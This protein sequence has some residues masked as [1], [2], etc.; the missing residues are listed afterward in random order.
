MSFGKIDRRLSSRASLPQTAQA[1]SIMLF[2]STGFRE[3]RVWTIVDSIHSSRPW[4]PVRT[5]DHCSKDYWGSAA[6]PS[7]AARCGRTKSTPPGALRRRRRQSR[8]LVPASKFR[9]MGCVPAP[10][11]PRINVVRTA[12]IQPRLVR[13]TVNVAATPAVRGPAMAKNSAVPPIRVPVGCPRHISCATGR[14]G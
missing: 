4:R 5:G 6:Q 2:A 12:A 14:T 1:L 9:S 11:L 3:V 7:S 8:S 10:L 13:I